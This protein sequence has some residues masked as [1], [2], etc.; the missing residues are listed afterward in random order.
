ME[1]PPT[2]SVIIIAKNEEDEIENCL[3]CIASQKIRPE[4]IV[5]DGQSSDKTFSIARKY[6]DRIVLEL[7]PSGV[8]DAR[9]LGFKVASGDIVAYCDADARPPADWTEKILNL[10]QDNICI[11]GPIVPY[12]NNKKVARILKISTNFIPRLFQRFNYPFICGP[13]MIFKKK[14]L[15]KNPFRMPIIEDWE[16]GNRLRKKGRVKFFKE[17]K[18]PVSDRRYSKNFFLMS[19]KYYFLNYIRLKL[20]QNLKTDGYWK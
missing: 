4:I 16:L 1:K 7:K 18:M 20:G 12:N 15:E 14:I 5:V 6:A 10:M 19:F 11:G 9:N 2:I 3:K 8:C 17:L 13:N